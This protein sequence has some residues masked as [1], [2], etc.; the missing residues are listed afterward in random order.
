MGPKLDFV[1]EDVPNVRSLHPPLPPYLSFSFICPTL[2]FLEIPANPPAAPSFFRISHFNCE[3]SRSSSGGFPR[4]F[5]F[6]RWDSG[7]PGDARRR[8]DASATFYG[9]MHIS[10]IFME[11]LVDFFPALCFLAFWASFLLFLYFDYER[12]FFLFFYSLSSFLLI[13]P[14]AFS[15]PALHFYFV[16]VSLFNTAMCLI[17]FM[18]SSYLW[19][20]IKF[21]FKH[22]IFLSLTRRGN[23]SAV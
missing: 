14:F 5:F 9:T 2:P 8:R 3:S 11:F 17:H 1:R 21:D 13:F 18:V 22:G 4:S 20:I 6:P 7:F 10:P 19:D 12:I 15:V 16:V 23:T